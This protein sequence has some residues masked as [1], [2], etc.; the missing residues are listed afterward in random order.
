MSTK[1]DG[2]PAFPTDVDNY[3]GKYRGQ[4][5][6]LRDHFAAKAI[7]AVYPKFRKMFEQEN[8]DMLDW[9]NYFEDIAQESYAIADAM[10]EARKA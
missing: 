4:G 5:L 8:E 3:A 1:D 10:L 9:E 6:S 2:G 7:D